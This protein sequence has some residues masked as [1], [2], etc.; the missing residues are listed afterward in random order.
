MQFP[1]RHSDGGPRTD[2][3]C[4]SA[5]R[6]HLEGVTDTPPSRQADARAVATSLLRA[7]LRRGQPLDRALA[8]D[9]DFAALD[10]RDR[11]FARLITATTLRRLGQIDLLIAGCLDSALPDA[12]SPV[13]DILRIGVAQLAFLGTPGH[14]AV[15]RTVAL[16]QDRRIAPRRRSAP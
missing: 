1:P 2:F 5:D 7:A 11:A 10:P 8:S 15:D 9:P 12:A 14:A 6:T 16:V 13:Q 3:S 4:H